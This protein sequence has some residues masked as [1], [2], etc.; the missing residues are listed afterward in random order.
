MACGE[1]TDMANRLCPACWSETEFIYEPA[2]ETCGAPLVGEGP[3]QCEE[4]FGSPPPWQDGVAVVV[5]G[6]ATA[7]V[8]QALKHGDRL[9]LV[10][11]IGSWMAEATKHVSSPAAV[12]VPVPIHLKRLLKRR[13]NQ[14]DLLGRQISKELSLSFDNSALKRTRPSVQQKEMTRETRIEN[15]IGSFGLEED[16]GLK[17][18]HVI[19]VDDVMTSG[20]TLRAAT[21]TLKTGGVQSVSISVFARVAPNL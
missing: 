10:P 19:L 18:Q 16:H 5:Y 20:A 12:V 1:E 15:Q 4:C 21:E 17:G 11:K 3:G 2:C 13:F 9:D 7:R 14:A 8:V 6:S